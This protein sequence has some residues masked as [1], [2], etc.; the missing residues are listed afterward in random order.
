M[1]SILQIKRLFQ[2]YPSTFE[3]GSQTVLMLAALSLD[4]YMTASTELYITGFCFT[5]NI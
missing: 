4:H 3:I 5:V 2:K 1:L